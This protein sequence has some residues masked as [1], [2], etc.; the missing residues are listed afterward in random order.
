MEKKIFDFTDVPEDLAESMQSA[1]DSTFEILLQAEKVKGE[2]ATLME[3]IGHGMNN[4]K[5]MI[6]KT[7]ETIQGTINIFQN[8]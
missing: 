3:L 5:E 4:A 2:D 6:R 8:K 7:E 1:Y